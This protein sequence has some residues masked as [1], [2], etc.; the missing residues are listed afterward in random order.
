MQLPSNV[1]ETEKLSSKPPTNRFQSVFTSS[2]GTAV[3]T[4][5]QL[6][7]C[8][9]SE[10]E[11][12][13]GRGDVVYS[14]SFCADFWFYLMNNHVIL[15]VCGAHPEHPYGNFARMIALMS[16]ILFAMF[17]SCVCATTKGN[18]EFIL[19]YGVFIILQTIFDMNAQY[20]SSMQCFKSEG[21]PV[22]YYYLVV[23]SRY[24][25][26]IAAVQPV[27]RQA[28]YFA[29]SWMFRWIMLLLLRCFFVH[30]RGISCR[31]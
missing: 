13:L 6:A 11:I 30:H 8:K 20:L 18:V 31:K 9:L 27:F 19:N 7:D 15:A 14:D 3:S 1:L 21:V 17:L 28:L 10:I 2:T 22:I 5:A 26:L 4:V 25:Y 23:G 29:T 24:K 16:S 12:K